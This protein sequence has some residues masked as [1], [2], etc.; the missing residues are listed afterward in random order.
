MSESTLFIRFD[1]SGDSQL[2]IGGVL[3]GNI[4]PIG[5]DSQ[6]RI[7]R[8]NV[9]IPVAESIQDALCISSPPGD[10]IAECILPNGEIVR[11]RSISSGSTIDIV[12][13]S[14]EGKKDISARPVYFE[15]F[16][17]QPRLDRHSSHS[18]EMMLYMEA[19]PKARPNKAW[20]ISVLSSAFRGLVRIDEVSDET[21]A[22]AAA[23]GEFF[24]EINSSNSETFLAG[25]RGWENRASAILAEEKEEYSRIFRNLLQISSPEHQGLRTKNL[26]QHLYKIP[27]SPANTEFGIRNLTKW[28]PE[29]IELISLPSSWKAIEGFFLNMGDREDSSF[30]INFDASLK[31]R[32]FRSSITVNDPYFAAIFSYLTTGSLPQ[33]SMILKRAENMLFEKFA[34][35]FAAAAG[36]YILIS[37]GKP[38][39]NEDWPRWIGNLNRRFTWLPDGAVAHGWLKLLEGDLGAAKESFIEAYKRG[40]PLFSLGIRKLAEGL[41]MFEED[42]TCRSYFS[43]VETTA[44]RTNMTECFTVTRLG[45]RMDLASE[46]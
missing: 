2:K 3:I 40:V 39:H 13:R 9:L 12:L 44:R 24:F 14:E 22:I 30:E 32:R 33:A 37:R 41:A 46:G 5:N 26:R 23:I 34:N 43:I 8:R 29:G 1:P 11:G 42:P 20:N 36:A 35:P 17:P 4:Y 15:E 28:T 19:A 18:S 45:P 27:P 7:A 31:Q 6:T 21:A 38:T 25:L 10:Y 16:E